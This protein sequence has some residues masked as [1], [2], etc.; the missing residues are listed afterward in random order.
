MRLNRHC[1]GC[2]MDTPATG[3]VALYKFENGSAIQLCNTCASRLA[4]DIAD[5]LQNPEQDCFDPD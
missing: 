5:Y 3:E 1:F 2:D 4:R